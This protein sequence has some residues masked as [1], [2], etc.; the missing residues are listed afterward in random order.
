M[1]EAKVSRGLVN[2]YF[3]SMT[4]LLVE[5]YKA[6]I[7]GLSEKA[8]DDMVRRSGSAGLELKAMVDVACGPLVFERVHNQAWIEVWALKTTMPE[9]RAVHRRVYLHYRLELTSVIQRIA[10]ERKLRIDADRLAAATIAFVDGLWLNW[11]I[12]PRFVS[13]KEARRACYAMLEAR[14]GPL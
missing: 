7:A 13:A 14:L 8:M 3:P 1:R 4:D 12:D 6:M 10:R 9:L 2:H 11:S 5:A